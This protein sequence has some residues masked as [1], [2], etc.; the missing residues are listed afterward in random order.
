MKQCSWCNQPFKPNVTYQIYCSPYCRESATKEKIFSR[1]DIVR[2][3]KRKLK[4]KKCAGGC[5]ITLSIYNDSNL[6]NACKINNKDVEKT[7]KKIKGMIRD[8]KTNKPE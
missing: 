2:R 3:Q 6:C 8:S 5:G 4:P 7:L 1:Y